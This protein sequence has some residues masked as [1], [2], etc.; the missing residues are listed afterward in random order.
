MSYIKCLSV[1]VPEIEITNEEIAMNFPEWDSE[2]IISKIGVKKRFVAKIDEFV[3]DLSVRVIN[4]LLTEFEI[5]KSTIDYLIICTQ[6]PD[7]ILP[8]TACIVQNEVG[9][10]KNCGAIDINQGCSGYIY[11]L[12]LAD[13]L[14]CTGNFRN[15]LLV[16][17]ET[18]S[19]HIHKKDKGNI[20]IFGDAASATLISNNGKYKIGKF[21]LGTDGAGHTN[22]IV[23]NGGAKFQK[24]DNPDNLDNYLYMNGSEI[25]NF[26]AKN[27]P[28]LVK[29]NLCINGFSDID[30]L[31][32]Y[33]FHQANTFMLD[34]L[35][36]RIGI[37]EEKFVIDMEN[38]G[39]TVSSSIPLAFKSLFDK[40][41]QNIMLVGFG[42][43]Y[44]WGA[45]CISQD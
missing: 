12:S 18:Y 27:I 35:R 19:K 41:A 13:A 45:V 31:D 28:P 5:D 3:S 25:F 17:A 8:T 32:L 10:N 37:A 11:G 34:F 24:D 36:K 44:S 1:Y 23:K 2:K 30:T 9:L 4:Q 20:S 6:S 14:I 42:V 33:I 22:L 43:G 21:S 7:Y 29:E 15:V 40:N 16:T 39:N 26:T 38:Y